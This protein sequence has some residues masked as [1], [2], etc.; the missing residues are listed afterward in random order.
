MGAFCPTCQTWGSITKVHTSDGQPP[1]KGTDVIF[2][3]LSC[4]HAFGSEEFNTYNKIA[5]RMKAE[6]AE[7]I[8]EVE[9]DTQKKIGI[10]FQKF[11][12]AKKGSKK[13]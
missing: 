7:A 13:P 11:V 10:E 6:A 3:S 8:R 4:K 12:E 5:N 1:D 9:F 2:V